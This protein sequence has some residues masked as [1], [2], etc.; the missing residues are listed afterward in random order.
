MT[1]YF[2]LI[3]ALFAGTL[4]YYVVYVNV[5]QGFHY[6]PKLGYILMI[7]NLV[8]GSWM[9]SDIVRYFLY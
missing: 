2:M 1:N 3:F 8:F 6:N 5:R 4:N 7:L 9:Y